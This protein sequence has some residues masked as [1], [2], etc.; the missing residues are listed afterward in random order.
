MKFL[1]GNWCRDSK[2]TYKW[3]KGHADRGNEELNKEEILNIEAD[4]LWDVIRN[5]AT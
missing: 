2:I 1:Q 5:E 4:A 3:V